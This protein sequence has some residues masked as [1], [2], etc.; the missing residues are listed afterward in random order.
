MHLPPKEPLNKVLLRGA[1]EDHQGHL[2]HHQ[3]TITHILAWCFLRVDGTQTMEE[4]VRPWTDPPLCR[5]FISHLPHL[6]GLPGRHIRQMKSLQETTTTGVT[7]WKELWKNPL[8]RNQESI[9]NLS[10]AKWY[11]RHF[12]HL[13]WEDGNT[14][15]KQHFEW[16]LVKYRYAI[17]KIHNLMLFSNKWLK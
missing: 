6:M 5:H 4:A 3:C 13:D 15:N 2:I 12:V 10:F 14:C 8:K 17:I 11:P 1:S 16:T 9:I 7:R